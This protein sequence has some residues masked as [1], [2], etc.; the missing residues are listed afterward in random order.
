MLRAYCISASEKVSISH[1]GYPIGLRERVVG[2]AKTS[3]RRMKVFSFLP[4]MAVVFLLW[5]YL[6]PSI[7]TPTVTAVHI[8]LPGDTSVDINNWLWSGQR[9]IK[10]GGVSAPLSFRFSWQLVT[11]SISHSF[12]CVAD[13]TEQCSVDCF[14]FCLDEWSSRR[15]QAAVLEAKPSASSEPIERHWNR[16]IHELNAYYAIIPKIHIFVFLYRQL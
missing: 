6:L 9:N 13:D 16:Y 4:T 12:C 10:N 1:P 5:F 7:I 11:R 15:M 2:F 8:S 14:F 3:L